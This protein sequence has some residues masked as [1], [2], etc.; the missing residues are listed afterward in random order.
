MR[1]RKTLKA[2][3]LIELLVVIVIIA[4]LLSILVPALRKVKH[5]GM[6]VVCMNGIKSQ[7]RM[8]YLWLRDNNDRFYEHN[9]PS[10]SYVRVWDGYPPSPAYQKYSRAY[11][12]IDQYMD[13]ADVLIC[14]WTTIHAKYNVG[15]GYYA[16][17]EWIHPTT[18][19]HGAW[20]GINPAT[21]NPM[22]AI[23]IPYM[24]YGNYR[25]SGGNV[26]GTLPLYDFT[27]QE[28]G[29]RVITS[30]AWPTRGDECSG[31]HV[32][33][34][35][36]VTYDGSFFWDTSHGGQTLIQG[37][38][39]SYATVS[40]TEDQPMGYGDGHVEYNMRQEIKPRASGTPAGD[41]YY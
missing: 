22:R 35:H 4:M 14:P 41:V 34:S 16:D 11:T 40:S 26:K 37:S 33:I 3:T 27:P 5:A 9:T 8:Q 29:P 20:R 13:N 15:L 19:V 1:Y 24:W 25:V 39:L 30:T 17:S 31:H 18:G 32:L 7:H 10:P 28:G 2:F 6:R 12:A 36:R 23:L 38:G 21:G